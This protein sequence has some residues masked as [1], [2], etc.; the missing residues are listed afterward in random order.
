M[1][2]LILDEQGSISLPS[3]KT[4]SQKIYGQSL[5]P[6]SRRLL[7]TIQSFLQLVD[8]IRMMRILKPFWLFYIYFFLKYAI[9]NDIF[10][11]HLI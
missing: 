11:I 7:K 3:R 5:I 9:Q 10:Y 8:M 4:F 2:T 6:C 1:I